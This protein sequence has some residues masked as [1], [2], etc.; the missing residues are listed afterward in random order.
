M[1]LYLSDHTY[2]AGDHMTIADLALVASASTMEVLIMAFR[3]HQFEIML[4]MKFYT[5]CG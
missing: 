4:M 1:S 5:A 2:A 3:F